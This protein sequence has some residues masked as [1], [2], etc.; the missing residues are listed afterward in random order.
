[1]FLCAIAVRQRG[2]EESRERQAF[3]GRSP[4]RGK[5]LIVSVQAE[6]LDDMRMFD[7]FQFLRELP[8]SV[9]EKPN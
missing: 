9:N 4:K 3:D 8:L 6:I 5:P 7:F 2:L 1:M